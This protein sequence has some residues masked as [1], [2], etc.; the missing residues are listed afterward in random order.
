MDKTTFGKGMALLCEVFGKESS[1]LFL[2]AYFLVLK[3][4]TDKQFED[5]VAGILKNKTFS[6]MPLPAEILEFAYG[7]LEDKTLLA[8]YK[9]ETAI[10]KHGYY[11]SV[12][13]DDPV[14]HMAI[15]AL[16]GWQTICVMQDDEWKWKKKEFMSFYKTFTHNP[17]Q[18]PPKL[19]GFHDH[20]NEINGYK[21]YIKPPV[22]VGDKAKARLVLEHDTQDDKD[23][24][25]KVLQLGGIGGN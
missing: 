7:S 10:K 25:R 4:L 24:E 11:T 12:V 8:L 20:N 23:T 2:K 5:A 13:F 19:V 16:D 15:Q 3:D 22:L 1:E 17:V 9:L 21:E 18:Y 14:I 6:K